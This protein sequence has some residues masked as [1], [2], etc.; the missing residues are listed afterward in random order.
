LRGAA[1]EVGTELADRGILRFRVRREEVRRCAHV[2]HLSGDERHLVRVGCADPFDADG[3]FLPPLLA[4]QEGLGQHVER[5]P[6]P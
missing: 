2:Q 1:R 5:P 4:Q 3:G 6:L